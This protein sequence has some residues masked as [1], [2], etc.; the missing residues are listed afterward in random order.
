M[1]KLLAI[2]LL[3][4]GLFTLPVLISAQCSGGNPST[5]FTAWNY[6][7]SIEE[8][9]NAARRWE[10]DNR[11]LASDCLGYMAAPTGGWGALSNAQ[12]ALYIHNSERT[13]RGR[14]PFY[15]VETHLNTVS[16]N[17]S[18]WQIANDVFDHIGDSAFGMGGNY[19]ACPDGDLTPGSTTSQRINSSSSLSGCWQG[20]GENISLSSSAT[21]LV[22]VS[23]YGFLYEDGICCGWGHRNNVLVNYSDDWG[24]TG[25]EGFIG[26]GVAS[27]LNYTINDGNVQ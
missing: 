16:Q 11:G 27:S 7:L 22:A 3:G 20:F 25:T 2:T 18:S 17:H 12:I 23:I 24:S 1:G 14:L 15:G 19:Y 5:D 10:E 6:S 4:L 9:F 13:A 21:H 26:V 8:N